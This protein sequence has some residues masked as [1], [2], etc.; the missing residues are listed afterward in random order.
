[1]RIGI[2]A[3]IALGCNRVLRSG[4]VDVDVTADYARLGTHPASARHYHTGRCPVG[5]TTQDD[6]ARPRGLTPEAAHRIA[7]YLRALTME[8]RRS[9]A[10]AARPTCA[11]W[12]PRTSRR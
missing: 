7:N 1:M 3:L 11:T 12:S 2:A 5:I 4:P 9:P 10:P 6:R 8:V